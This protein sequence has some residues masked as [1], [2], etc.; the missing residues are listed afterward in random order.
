M[1]Y[2]RI[3]VDP[4]PK[5][6]SARFI[7]EP[8]LID[9]SIYIESVKDIEKFRL[10]EAEEDNIRI[11]VPMDLNAKA[12]L[13]RLNHLIDHYGEANY[14]NEANFSFDVY[15]LVSQIEIYDRI[16]YIRHMTD[17][18]REHSEEGK[19]LVA[20]FIKMLEDIPDGCADCFPF[21]LIEELRKEYL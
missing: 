5:E 6:Q 2:H 19:K 3:D 17:D 13:R 4:I 8:W 11:Y 14:R 7:N 10:P 18:A 15:Q 16:W 20:E 21:E 12:I 9:G 1:D